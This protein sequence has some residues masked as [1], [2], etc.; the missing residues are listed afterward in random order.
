M[1]GGGGK[2]FRRVQ[3]VMALHNLSKVAQDVI[4]V[5]Y[6]LIILTIEIAIKYL[7]LRGERKDKLTAMTLANRVSCKDEGFHRHTR[8]DGFEFLFVSQMKNNDR[9]FDVVVQRLKN[10][11][12]QSQV[13][14]YAL[15]RTHSSKNFIYSIFR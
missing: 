2:S 8:S 4:Q 9:E 7:Q 14:N 1:V 3:M 6:G 12:P 11:I 15:R 13:D 10:E 5:T